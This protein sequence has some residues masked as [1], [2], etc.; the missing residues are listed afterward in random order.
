MCN[1]SKPD[2]HNDTSLTIRIGDPTVFLDSVNR[3]YATHLLPYV[4]SSFRSWGSSVSIVSD[5]RLD[6]GSIPQQRQRN[7]PLVSVQISYEAHP[8][9][10]PKGTGSSFPGGKARPG[11][12]ADHSLPSSAKVKNEKVLYSSPHWRCMT[13]RDSFTLLSSSFT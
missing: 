9:S 12:D 6:W 2:T 10:Y 7:F 13:L 5:Y 4:A 11:R 8:A 1:R 3:W